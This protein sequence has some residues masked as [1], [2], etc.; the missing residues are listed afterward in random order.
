MN[1]VNYRRQAVLARI[2]TTLDTFYMEQ[3]IDWDYDVRR[4]LDRILEIALK[5]LEFGEGR[6][7]ERALIIV[8]PSSG[9]GLEVGAGWRAEQV[10]SYSRTVVNET[11]A[12]GQPVLYDGA[13]NDPRFTNAD[14]LQSLEVV[15]LMCVPILSDT[16]RLGAIYLERRDAGYIFTPEDVEFLQAFAT[17]I[18]PYVK[19]ALKHQEHVAAIRALKEARESEAGLPNLL[20]NSKPMQRVAELARVAAGVEKTVLISGESGSG[21]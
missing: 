2:H 9:D 3:E 11:L 18:A 15:S 21:K 5:E 6:N 14:S 16:R 1:R 12:N 17:T 7:T 10:E 20:G 4:L 19:T 8:Q 13:S